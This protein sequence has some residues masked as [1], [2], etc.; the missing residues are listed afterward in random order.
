MR[1]HPGEVNPTTRLTEQLFGRGYLWP[2]NDP[3]RSQRLR[4]AISQ[5]VNDLP[6]QPQAVEDVLP[7]MLQGKH[8]RE[9]CKELGW[10]VLAS[11]RIAITSR[12]VRTVLKIALAPVVPLFFS[13]SDKEIERRTWTSGEIEERFVMGQSHLT[14]F[15]SALR[16]DQSQLA[17]MFCERYQPH[18][19]TLIDYLLID[20]VDAFYTYV[21]ALQALELQG[22]ALEIVELMV[23][24]K[25]IETQQVLHIS[26]Q[27]FSYHMTRILE[28]L[29]VKMRGRL[30]S[31]WRWPSV[32]AMRAYILR[33]P[34]AEVEG[35]LS[36]AD[37]EF[38]VLQ[39]HLQATVGG[40]T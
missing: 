39:R 16:R 30:I 33:T 6:P 36:V 8:W 27:V 10:P 20:G 18:A 31:V 15:L 32:E 19:P 29:D 25:S 9:I 28:D 5:Y 35:L 11:G 3:A 12:L 26:R 2:E 14:V 38:Q 22:T 17:R 24:R 1:I 34:W 23:V 37:E 7:K 4:S 13:I 40:G 21:S